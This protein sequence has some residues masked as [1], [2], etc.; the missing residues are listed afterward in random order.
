MSQTAE[1]ETNDGLESSWSQLDQDNNFLSTKYMFRG[2]KGL[3][4]VEQ[5]ALGEQQADATA[6]SQGYYLAPKNVSRE[7]LI[8]IKSLNPIR[9]NG[10]QLYTDCGMEFAL[11]IVSSQPTVP[12]NVRNNTTGLIGADVL[13]PTFQLS[14]VAVTGTAAQRTVRLYPIPRFAQIQVSNELLEDMESKTTN[15]E[16][17]M[18]NI[19]AE[20]FAAAELFDTFLGVGVGPT[21]VSS[22]TIGLNK[23]LV[24]TT[25]SL[26]LPAD[27]TLA[28]WSTAAD[29]MTSVAIQDA[30]W[31][32]HPKVVSRFSCFNGPKTLIGRDGK[33]VLLLGP[34]KM[35]LNTAIAASGTST[36]QALAYFINPSCYA[37]CETGSPLRFTRLDELAGES[38]QTI[39]QAMRRYDCICTDVTQALSFISA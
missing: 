34:N 27:F 1:I 21:T 20:Q 37:Y 38:G 36:T 24:D 23:Q 33:P 19:F 6:L 11:P 32:V 5:R 15:L 10:A 22:N 17:L 9:K 35:F 3:T 28:N 7:T 14:E 26:V 4:S 12:S 25:R 29:L 16:K 39:F 31:V 8:K 30:I 2:W 13:S 18:Q